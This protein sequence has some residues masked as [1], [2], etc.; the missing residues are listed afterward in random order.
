MYYQSLALGLSYDYVQLDW[1]QLS[2]K[3]NAGGI[4]ML[5]SS[6]QYE[7]LDLILSICSA[8]L[9]NHACKSP[10]WL[11]YCLFP[12]VNI[13]NRYS[14]L[15]LLDVSL[16]KT[17]NKLFHYIQ[18]MGQTVHFWNV[19]FGRAF[20]QKLLKSIKCNSTKTDIHTTQ[21]NTLWMSL[22]H[23][24]CIFFKIHPINDS[25]PSVPVSV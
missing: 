10:F 5:H 11:P 19:V 4:Q 13:E 6:H 3:W 12:S 18:A 14:S 15:G 1:C 22:L 17:Y 8:K 21:V 16:S 2:H 20:F 9:G 24:K 23:H 7:C 25:L